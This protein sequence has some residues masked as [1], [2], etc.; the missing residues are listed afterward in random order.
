[1]FTALTVLSV[2]SWAY[3]AL[4]QD[5][6]TLIVVAII[7]AC[8]ALLSARWSRKA[9][10]EARRRRTVVVKTDEGITITEEEIDELAEPDGRR[11][12]KP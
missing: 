8:S 4:S 6:A 3:V 2:S 1:M 12:R 10:K 11:S 7:G 9:V 5:N